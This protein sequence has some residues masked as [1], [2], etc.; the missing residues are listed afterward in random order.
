M[1]FGFVMGGYPATTRPL[2]FRPIQRIPAQGTAED[3]R[4]NSVCLRSGGGDVLDRP[5]VS[6][7]VENPQV[8]RIH[9]QHDASC[10]G[11]CSEEQAEVADV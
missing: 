3:Q 4:E 11:T 7:R 6:A 5:S 1:T 8:V 2:L 10:Q 9:Q